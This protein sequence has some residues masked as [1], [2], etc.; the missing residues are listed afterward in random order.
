MRLYGKGVTALVLI[1]LCAILGEIHADEDPFI[2]HAKAFLASPEGGGDQN[3]LSN[4]VR[5]MEQFDLEIYTSHQ[6]A[7]EQILKNGWTGS[8]QNEMKILRSLQPI[9]NEI[10]RGDEKQFVK[11]PPVESGETVIPN[12]WKLQMPGKLMVIQSRYCEYIGRPDY[13]TEWYKHALIFAQRMCDENSML[14]AKLM[15]VALEKMALEAFQQFLVRHDIGKDSY[16]KIANDLS[17]LRESDTPFWRF[18][19]TEQTLG[20]YLINNPDSY[21]IGLQGPLTPKE[22]EALQFFKNNKETAIRQYTQFIERFEALLKKDYPEI[23]R[24]DPKTLIADVHPVL[25][26]SMLMP[27]FKEVA[28][29]EGVTYAWWA[30]TI[31][32]AQVRAYRVEKGSLPTSLSALGEVGVSPPADPFSNTTIKYRVS[33]NSGILYSIGPDLIDNGGSPDYDPTNGTISAGDIAVSVQ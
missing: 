23:V 24:T 18:L 19:K 22:Q 16:L 31:A 29:G 13:A 26:E 30:L 20:Y 33:G 11:Y 6:A 25:R 32:T 14:I 7:F 4:Y 21:L 2:P 28:I 10:W 8:E 15:S 27:N 3:A 1:V 9:L 5:V 17:K 12:F